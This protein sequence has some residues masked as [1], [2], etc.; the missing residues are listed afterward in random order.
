MATSLKDLLITIIPQ[1][2]SWKAELHINWKNIIGHLSEHVQLLKVYDS[3]LL[4]GVKDSSWLQEMYLLSP[5]L[6]ETI[7]KSLDKPY[8][9]KLHFKNVGESEYTQQ[10]AAPQPKKEKTQQPKDQSKH[11]LTRFE[12]TTLDQVED[13]E[14]R[15]A[16]KEL[17][18]TCYQEKK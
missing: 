15:E 11:T 9:I 13:P 8:I 12:Q 6:I 2:T 3:A 16:L 1:Q 14:L 17:L 5:L 18:L 10:N 7:N 4:L